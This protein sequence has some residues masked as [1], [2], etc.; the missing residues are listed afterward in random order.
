MRVIAPLAGALAAVLIAAH[1]GSAPAPM[2][3][4]VSSILSGLLRFSPS[5]FA[6]L[7]RGGI[8]KHGLDPKATGEVAVAG[9]VRVNATKSRF[10]DAVRDIVRFKRSP[11][12]LE[13]GVFSTPPTL[14]DLSTL[15]VTRNDFDARTCRVTDCDVRLP[16]DVIRRFQREIDPR[17]PDV[18]QRTEAL[19]KQVLIADVNGYLTGGSTRFLSYDDGHRPIRPEEEFEGV[20]RDTPSA[21]ALLPALPDHLRNPAA[22]ALPGAEDLLYWSKENFGSAPP[23]I[24]VTHVA[25]VCP[26]APTCV[27]ASRDVYSSRYLDASLALTVATDGRAS[28]NTTYVVYVNRSRANALKGMF[29]GLRR[30]LVERRAKATLEDSLKALKNRLEKRR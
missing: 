29:S 11:D 14:A 30:A 22:N 4:R 21:A 27:I 26:S 28:A 5:D 9:A 17:A 12:V 18:Q 25:I 19:F 15:T 3:E 20:L 1:A 8:V 2:D 16:A 23:F 7:D 10:V 6:E 24:T 13:I